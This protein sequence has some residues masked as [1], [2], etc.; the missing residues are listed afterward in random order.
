MLVG[1]CDLRTAKISSG[2]H[3]ICPFCKSMVPTKYKVHAQ[4][5]AVLVQ[6]G[7]LSAAY[8]KR[9]E[10]GVW[11]GRADSLTYNKILKALREASS[12]GQTIE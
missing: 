11:G 8:R 12:K 2:G 3:W 10:N 1:N 5:D 4:C 7:G 6:R 9:N